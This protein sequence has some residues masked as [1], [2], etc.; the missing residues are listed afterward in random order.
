MQSKSSKS[1]WS[2]SPGPLAATILLISWVAFLV[3]DFKF[4]QT[5]APSGKW[6]GSELYGPLAFFQP[7]L[8]YSTFALTI[9]YL[10]RRWFWPET[11]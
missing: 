3:V 2:L 1:P 4:Q 10:A 5:V 6:P 8:K 7:V 11:A 9:G